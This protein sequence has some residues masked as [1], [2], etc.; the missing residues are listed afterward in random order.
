MAGFCDAPYYLMTSML[1][2]IVKTNDKFDYIVVTGDLMSHDVWNYNNIS[3]MSFI[4]NISDNLKT[5]FKDTP[6][7][8][9]IGNHEGV[10]IDNVA[11]HYAPRQWSMNWLYGSMLKNWGD[12]IP[13]DQNDTMI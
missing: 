6:I 13:G 4:K 3:H 1:D 11:P 2:H 12:Y 7:L 8:Q 9:V 5:Y 10:P